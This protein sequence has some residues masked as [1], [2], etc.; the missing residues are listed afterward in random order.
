MASSNTKSQLPWAIILVVGAAFGYL[1]THPDEAQQAAAP[2]PTHVDTRPAEGSNGSKKVSD[3]RSLLEQGAADEALREDPTQRPGYVDQFLTSPAVENGVQEDLNRANP[4][5]GD[6]GR[7][8]AKEAGDN[9]YPATAEGPADLSTQN[10]VAVGILVEERCRHMK[11]DPQHMAAM[12]Q[13]EG[14]DTEAEFNEYNDG[15]AK[16][17]LA[18]YRRDKDICDHLWGWYGPHGTNVPRAL[19]RR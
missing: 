18:A 12:F 6:P 14:I 13:R 7:D 2:Q 16:H 19:V 1:K 9:E 10:A 17:I 11:L 4:P 8:A 15:T 3:A 5:S